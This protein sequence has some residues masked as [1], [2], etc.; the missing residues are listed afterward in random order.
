MVHHILNVEDDFLFVYKSSN[1]KTFWS[2]GPTLSSNGSRSQL[3]Y[4]IM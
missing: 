1:E 2:V 3:R 4:I